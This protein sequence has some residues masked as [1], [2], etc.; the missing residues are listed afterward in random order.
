[1]GCKGEADVSSCGYMLCG[2][3]VSSKQVG[4]PKEEE[5]EGPRRLY[6]SAWC[7]ESY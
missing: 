1:M 5:K 3:G 2:A 6:V 4:E 7:C